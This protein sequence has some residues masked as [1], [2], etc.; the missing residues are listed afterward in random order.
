MREL[1]RILTVVVLTFVIVLLALPAHARSPLVGVVIYGNPGDPITST[2][3]D[4]FLRGMA[5]LGYVEG[6]NIS[7]DVR[8]WGNQP[9]GIGSIMEDLARKRVDVILTHGTVAIRPAR[10][11]APT[12]PIVFAAAADPVSTGLIAS[13]GRPGGKLTGI[14][15]LTPELTVKRLELV[16]E[17]LPAARRVA[18]LLR[19]GWDLHPPFYA[20]LDAIAPTLGLE[21]RPFDYTD[22]PDAPKTAEMIMAWPADAMLVL[23]HPLS[24][25]TFF[26]SAES[27]PQFHALRTTIPTFCSFRSVAQRGCLMSYGADLADQFYRAAS[28]VGRILKGADPAE[29]PVQQPT[30]FDVVINMKTARALGLAI[31]TAFMYRVTETIE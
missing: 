11:H 5:D 10:E 8:F 31:P 29:L 22:V 25:L 30:K 27:S 3:R 28:Y 23:E 15:L 6:R 4:A 12:T 20:T 21:L 13:L 24:H 19:R 1:P 16:R 26:P 18:V 9:S 14:G 17:F 2:Y 7:Y